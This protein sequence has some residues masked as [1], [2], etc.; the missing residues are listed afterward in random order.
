MLTKSALLPASVCVLL[1]SQIGAADGTFKEGEVLVRFAQKVDRTLPTLAER[2]AVLAPYGANVIR[3]Y[4][5][6]P[7]LSLV[8]LR[9]G[10]TVG[11]AITALKTL[12]AVAYV[13]PNYRIQLFSSFPNDPNFGQQ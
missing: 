4:K 1:I 8:K 9:E 11:E 13:E 12:S 7:G 3:S 2:N 6:V 10:V 5:L